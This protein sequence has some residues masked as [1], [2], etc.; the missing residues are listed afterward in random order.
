[1]TENNY[2][3][4]ITEVKQQILQSRYQAARLVNR[5]QLLLYFV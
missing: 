4:F 2:T 3:N 1:M 5:E